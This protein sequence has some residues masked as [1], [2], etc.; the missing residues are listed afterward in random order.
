MGVGKRRRVLDTGWGVRG[1]TLERGEKVHGVTVHSKGQWGL[2]GVDNPHGSWAISRPCQI[3]PVTTA[4]LKTI[5]KLNRDSGF[6]LLTFLRKVERHLQD[7]E[8][9]GVVPREPRV[10]SS[11]CSQI[12]WHLS[13]AASCQIASLKPK[14]RGSRGLSYKTAPFP[15]KIIP[16]LPL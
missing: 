11:S 6:S 9:A 3:L 8:R 12:F 16:E 2:P 15:T 7:W 1:E 13:G 10:R 14:L 4:L 5:R